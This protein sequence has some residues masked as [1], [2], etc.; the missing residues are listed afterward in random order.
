VSTVGFDRT[1][2][3][4][5]LAR[6]TTNDSVRRAPS[7]KSNVFVYTPL[8]AVVTT[9]ASFVENVKVFEPTRDVKEVYF[10]MTRDDTVVDGVRAT[11]IVARE[12]VKDR[13]T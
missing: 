3:C 13:G 4:E 12:D 10:G 1:K 2:R 5:V 11:V 9:N 6:L 7:Y 8:F